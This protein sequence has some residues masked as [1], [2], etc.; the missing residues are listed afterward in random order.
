MN[1]DLFKDTRISWK[2]KGLYCYLSTIKKSEKITLLLQ[3]R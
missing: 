3:I 2:A 1:K